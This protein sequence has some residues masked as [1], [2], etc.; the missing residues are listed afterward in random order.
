[1]QNQKVATVNRKSV[2]QLRPFLHRIFWKMRT[3]EVKMLRLKLAS[4]DRFTAI[5]LSKVGYLTDRAIS[6][7]RK[8]T[9]KILVSYLNLMIYLYKRVADGE[10]GIVEMSD[11]FTSCKTIAP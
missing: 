1:M 7:P 5:S 9:V 3:T 2:A 6:M 11:V 8:M 4:L 10:T